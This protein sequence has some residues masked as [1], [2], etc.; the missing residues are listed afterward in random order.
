MQQ[1]IITFLSCRGFGLSSL[2][3]HRN[4]LVTPAALES[5]VNSILTLFK[6]FFATT[7]VCPR[8]P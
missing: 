7:R 6:A 3:T 1:I 5:L 8:H 2:F 4:S